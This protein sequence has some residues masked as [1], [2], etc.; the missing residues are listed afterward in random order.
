MIIHDAKNLAKWWVDNQRIVIF[1][2]WVDSQR[3]DEK[4]QNDSGDNALIDTFEF[5]SVYSVAHC[6]RF[7]RKNEAIPIKIGEE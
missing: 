1:K 4:I 7:I 3:R 2:D 5:N 6:F